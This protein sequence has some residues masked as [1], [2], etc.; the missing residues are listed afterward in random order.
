MSALLAKANKANVKLKL[1]K[2]KL[3]KTTKK[4]DKICTKLFILTLLI[5]YKNTELIK[6]LKIEKSDVNHIKNLVSTQCYQRSL[7]PEY[8]SF[9]V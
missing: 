2:L 5:R 1:K 7:L 4:A 8:F 6:S 3:A 9:T